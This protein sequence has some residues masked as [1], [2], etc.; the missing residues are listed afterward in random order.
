MNNKGFAISTMLY[1]LSIVGLLLAIFLLQTMSA[2]RSEQRRLVEAMEEELDAYSS[3]TRYYTYKSLN[4]RTTRFTIPKYETGWYKIECWSA[5]RS[6]GSNYYTTQTVKIQ[7]RTRLY[8][9]LGNK[10]GNSVA[11]YSSTVC[12]GKTSCSTSGPQLIASSTSNVSTGSSNFTDP[13]EFELVQKFPR[14]SNQQ[15]LISKVASDSTISQYGRVRITL[16]SRENTYAPYSPSSGG[17]VPAGT[18]YILDAETSKALSYKAPT[19][20]D[21][22][23]SQSLIFQDLEGY[24]NQKWI[25]DPT[26][27]SIVNHQTH[28]SLRSETTGGSSS[29]VYADSEFD[30]RPFEK[31]QI[32]NPT[33]VSGVPRVQIKVQSASIYLFHQKDNMYKTSLSGS[34]T[35]TYFYLIPAN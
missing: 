27:N 14:I 16:V 35:G 9:T 12:N 8:I 22:I 15:Y 13:E 21:T 1:G 4:G 7:E 18:Y 26:T 23:I 25:Y 28:Y 3:F 6:G 24:N 10:T 29:A 34:G 31:W 2:T 30:N 20:T 11:D 33:V 19:S 32:T 5:F 17:T